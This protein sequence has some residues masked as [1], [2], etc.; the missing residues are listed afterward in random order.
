MKRSI[1]IT[2]SFILLMNAAQAQNSFGIAGGATFSK[3]NAKSE[4]FSISTKTH[5]GFTAGVVGIFS[6]GENFG[7]RPELN[8]T[9]KGGDMSGF[10]GEDDVKVKISLNY[11]ELP[12]NFVYVAKSSKGK[13]FGG[14]GPYVAY[15]LSGKYKENGTSDKIVFGNE[16]DADFKRF[17]AGV[18][19]IVGYEL[20][21]G[22][23]LSAN[24]NLGV[25]NISA[26]SDEK[27][28]LNYFGVKIGYMFPTSKKVNQ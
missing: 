25:T 9:E 18:N 23:F 7:F 14:A 16:E 3:F 28:R 19:A 8:F 26:M 11:L 22:L 24:Y 10:D 21:G 20:K 27:D 2:I 13:F 1:L 15:G 4:G 6:L 5:I 17:D 12:L